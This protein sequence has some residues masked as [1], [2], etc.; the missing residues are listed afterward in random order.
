MNILGLIRSFARLK[1]LKRDDY[2][3][4]IEYQYTN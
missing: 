1:K 3:T 2:D 4:G